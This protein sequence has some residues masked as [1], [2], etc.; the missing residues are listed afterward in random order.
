MAKNLIPR[1]DAAVLQ[2]IADVLGAT[3]GGLTGAEIAHTLAQVGVPDVS[4]TM[5][6]RHRLFNALAER[7]NKDRVG[8]CV[9]AFMNEAMAPVRYRDSPALF[10]G[11]QD[12]LNEVLIHAGY[13]IINEG[14]VGRAQSGKATTLAQA[15][16]RAGT[17]RTELRRRGTHPDLLLYCT[18]E[19][20]QKNN[21]HALL[22]AAKSIPDR[23]RRE[24]E[25]T[26]DGTELVEATLTNANG[27]VLAI[28][29]GRTATDRSEQSGFANL[30]IGLLGLYRNPTAH[31][32]K[33]H[34]VVSDEELIEALTAMSMVH[35]RLDGAIVARSADPP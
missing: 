9:V 5:T 7:Q 12:D 23:I 24:T 1:F 6:K 28:N 17:I 26:S 29:A 4:P 31:E 34:R 30:V 15:A 20:L 21:F 16:E 2:G 22:E 8:N 14:K 3:D 35:R 19:L 32:P 13:R 33:I 27:P 11:R 10:S 18:V 25:Q